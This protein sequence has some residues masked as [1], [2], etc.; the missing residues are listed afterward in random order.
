M[1]WNFIFGLES[2]GYKELSLAGGLTR[3]FAIWLPTPFFPIWDAGM[4]M[5]LR[6]VPFSEQT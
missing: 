6:F 3:I 5:P 1:F 4:G 2:E